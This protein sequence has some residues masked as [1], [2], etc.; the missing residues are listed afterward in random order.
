MNIWMHATKPRSLI[1][2]TRPCFLGHP[3]QNK[4]FS[5]YGN[6]RN[7]YT[8]RK[9]EEGRRGTNEMEVEEITIE[10][11]SE[12]VKYGARYLGRTRQIDPTLEFHA[13]KNMENG[14]VYGRGFTF[15]DPAMVMDWDLGLFLPRMCRQCTFLL[16][17][18]HI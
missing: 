7:I 15:I 6:D 18:R 13:C 3:L 1:S 5:F 11:F 4:V 16:F 8:C 9:T 17:N 2:L 12:N 10:L 14:A